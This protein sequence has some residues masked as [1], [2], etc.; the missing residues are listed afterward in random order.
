[1]SFFSDDKAQNN[2]TMRQKDFGVANYNEELR[3][4]VKVS[5]PMTVSIVTAYKVV[6]LLL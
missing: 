5:L 2:T 3:D 1:M 6:A 4:H